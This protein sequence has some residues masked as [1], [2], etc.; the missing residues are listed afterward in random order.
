MKSMMGSK[1]NFKTVQVLVLLL[2]GAV[3]FAV[4]HGSSPLKPAETVHALLH[5][6][7]GSQAAAIIWQLR[8]PRIILAFIV[9]AGLACCGVVFQAILRNGLAEPYTLGVSSGSALGATLGIIM[10]L[11]SIYVTIF[12]FI[13]SLITISVVYSIASKKRFANPTLILAGIALG[14]L[15]S[16]MILLIFS[17]ARQESVHTAIIWLM[18]DLSYT[19]TGLIKATGFFVIAGIMILNVFSRDIDAMCLGDE[20]A[21]HLGIEVVHIKKILFVTASLITGACVASAGIIGFVGLVIP[22]ICRFIFGVTHRRLLISSAF[23]GAAFLVFCDML[24]RTVISPLELPVGVITGIFGGIF[25]LGLII[26]S[27]KWGSF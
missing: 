20:K 5:P 26:K 12:S 9:G 25:F 21:R 6:A 8:L 1:V 23:L 13:G 22:H 7:D 3:L 18:G 10:N 11:G 4:M 15:F 19:K 24:A 14:L 27:K 2:A 16:S 17:I